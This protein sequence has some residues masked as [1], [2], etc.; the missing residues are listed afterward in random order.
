MIVATVLGLAAAFL[1][2]LSAFLQQRAARR[3]TGG[4][5]SIVMQAR[6]LRRL[7]HRLPR[8]RTWL[9][10]WLTNLCGWVTQAAALKLGS[11]AAVQPLMSA[12]LLFAVGLASAEQRR[13]PRWQD[14]AS[15]LTVCLGLVLLLTT[16]G[17][18]PLG[19]SARREYVLLATA[20]AAGLIVL[21]VAI[22]RLSA[23]WVTS[24]LLGVAAGVCHA[25]NAVFIKMTIEDLT[26]R[27]VAATAVDWPGYALAL[28]TL[29]GLVLGQLAFASGALPPAVAAINVTNPIVA[30]AAGLLAFDAPV[31]TAPGA[32]A[33]LTASGVLIA[34]GVIGLAHS[35]TAR[36]MYALPTR[37]S[38]DD[39]ERA[40]DSPAGQDGDRR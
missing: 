31:S 21:L 17:R 26:G 14:W 32:L 4:D 12:Q 7:A 20:C 23:P 27:G 18:P 34:A 10:G 30:L 35:P 9:R 24:M 8:S 13:W 25:M 2:A 5:T 38:T 11:V 39:V 40:T 6:G 22:G 3:A 1:F 16:E 33:A 29:S 28:S 15:A 37:R 19:G 36:A